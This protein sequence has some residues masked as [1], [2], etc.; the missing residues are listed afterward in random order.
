MS[1]F[2]YPGRGGGLLIVTREKGACDFDELMNW[3]NRC[4]KYAIGVS[5]LKKMLKFTAAK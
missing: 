3:P 2:L 1:I 4:E 5:V